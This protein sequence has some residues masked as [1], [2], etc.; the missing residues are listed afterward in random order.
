MGFAGTT[1]RKSAN[2]HW[3][4]NNGIMVR[5]RALHGHSC[6]PRTAWEKKNHGLLFWV[7]VLTVLAMLQALIYFKFVLVPLGEC[8]FHKT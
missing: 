1:W 5:S 2:I 4:T 6:C 7:Q 8:R 3:L